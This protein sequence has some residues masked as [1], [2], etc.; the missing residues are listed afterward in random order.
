MDKKVKRDKKVNVYVPAFDIKA[1]L[2]EDEEREDDLNKPQKR[3]KHQDLIDEFIHASE[4]SDITI[5]IKKGSN[6]EADSLVLSGTPQGEKEEFF[7]ETL[8]KI[9][10]KQHKFEK[11]IEIFK[12]LSLKYPEKSIYFADQIRF[13]EKLV[14]NL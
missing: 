5:S 7:T 3:L 14:K 11:A 2:G 12:K 10:I 13:F 9:Y 1:L 4:S 8:A 6:Q